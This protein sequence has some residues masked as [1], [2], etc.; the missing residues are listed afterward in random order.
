MLSSIKCP[1]NL[2]LIKEVMG[3]L[4]TFCFPFSE[5]FSPTIL[6]PVAEEKLS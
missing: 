4:R 6:S 1:S 5:Q 2:T 3:S